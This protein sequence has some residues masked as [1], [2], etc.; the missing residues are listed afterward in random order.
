MRSEKDSSFAPRLLRGKRC[1]LLGISLEDYFHVGAFRKLIRR[2]HWNRFE[3]SLEAATN[4]TLALLDEY[5]AKATFFTLGWVAEN[6]PELVRHAAERGH[7][8]ANSGFSHRGVA[9]L[10]AHALRDDLLRG[11]E[12]IERATGRAP[13]GTRIP[14]WL[15]ERELW[16][17]DVVAGLGY[18]YDSSFRPLGSD[19]R[20]RSARRFPFDHVSGGRRLREFPVPT[21]RVGTWLVPIGGGNWVR[22][23]PQWFVRQAIDRWHRTQPAPFS[24]Y[25]HV[26]ELAQAQPRITAASW[27][28]SVRH[29]RN[30]D[31]VERSLR[32]LLAR[33]PFASFAEYLEL[34]ES[35]A[36]APPP[37]QLARENIR[38]QPEPAAHTPRTPV[39]VVIPCYNESAT[40]PYLLKS[41]TAVSAELR[42]RYQ[43]SFVFVDDGSSDDTWPVLQSLAARR[44]DCHLV[45][46]P[47][48]RG[49]AQAVQSGLVA[50]PDEFVVSMDADCTYDPLQVTALLT[51]LEA[52][53]DLVTASPYHPRGRVSNVPRWRLLL[54]RTLSALYAWRLN[55]DIHTYTACFRAYRRSRFANVQLAHGGFLGIAEVMAR[56]LLGGL[57]VVEVPATLEVRLLGHSH[58]KVL[59]TIAGHL[60]LLVELSRWR[61]SNALPAASRPQ[62][63]STAGAA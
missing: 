3:S 9:D 53:A 27:L 8:I 37:A 34:P 25:V 7:E 18:A 6:L 58:I 31:L 60:R 21:A 38:L 11:H 1:H 52:G 19:C 35:P 22:Q 42:H 32:R 36:T 62:S 41:L 2:G 45:R 29:Y 61:G 63:T 40:L 28:T 50:A 47:Q 33:H 44:G 43:L 23:L 15:R 59:R 17:L 20:S 4:K 13:R 49:C 54:S 56:A 55:T 24:L 39:S 26:W 5:D 30:L 51:E 46:H 12:A 57:T 48:N 14:D 16:A 10:D